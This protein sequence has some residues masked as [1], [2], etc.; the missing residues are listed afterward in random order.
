MVVDND[1]GGQ[2]CPQ[3]VHE[4]VTVTM[5]AARTAGADIPRRS[6]LLVTFDGGAAGKTGTGGF[7]VWGPGAEL[8]Q[9]RA[10]W[11]GSGV[12]TNNVAEASAAIDA[13][14]WVANLDASR[15]K[16][17]VV[18]GDSQLVLDFICRRAKPKV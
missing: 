14:E 7:L 4:E 16:R 2:S 8:L 3:V 5:P 9:A 13:F 10:L 17:V 18:L 1:A 12:S 11:Y 15:S 6:D